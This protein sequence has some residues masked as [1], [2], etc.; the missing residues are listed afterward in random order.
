MQNGVL[1]VLSD[2]RVF[3]HNCN[4]KLLATAYVKVMKVKEQQ[5]ISIEIRRYT[6]KSPHAINEQK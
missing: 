4:A 6:R 2:L 3:S 1:K 5:S